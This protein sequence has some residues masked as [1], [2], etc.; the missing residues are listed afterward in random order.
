MY[1]PL[2]VWNYLVTKIGKNKLTV[3]LRFEGE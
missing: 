2:A 1:L 3:T